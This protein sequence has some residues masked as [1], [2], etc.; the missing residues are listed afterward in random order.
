ME[1]FPGIVLACRA[2]IL[3]VTGRGSSRCH[4]NRLPRTQVILNQIAADIDCFQRFSFLRST[5]LD[6]ELQSWIGDVVVWE[7]HVGVVVWVAWATAAAADAF[8]ADAE[9]GDGGGAGAA[10]G[11]RTREGRVLVRRSQLLRQDGEGQREVRLVDLGS[12]VQG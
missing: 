9:G 2:V 1:E 12:V 11:G 5:R 10:E 3:Y 7:R 4:T 8:R 6:R